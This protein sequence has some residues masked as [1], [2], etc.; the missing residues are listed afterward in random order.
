MNKLWVIFKVCMPAVFGVLIDHVFEEPSAIYAGAV[1]SL[2]LSIISYRNSNDAKKDIN[3]KYARLTGF[4]SNL[5]NRF[6]RHERK[7]HPLATAVIET[8]GLAAIKSSKGISSVTDCGAN[9]MHVHIINPEMQ[10]LVPSVN[11]DVN[12]HVSVST[13][14]AGISTV[15]ISWSNSCP[16]IIYLA[17]V[18]GDSVTI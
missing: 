13:D 14:E 8:K 15:K 10:Q 6:Y 9:E 12:E 17:V 18:G 1:L 16:G 5:K 7:P 4:Y 2:M 11:T 3:R